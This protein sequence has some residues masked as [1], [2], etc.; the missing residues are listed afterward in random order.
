[1]LDYRI[2]VNKMRIASIIDVKDEAPK[3]KSFTFHDK[4]C[5]DATPGQFVMIWIPG[6][7]EV[8]MSLSALD[9]NEKRATI[10][11]E[12]VGQATSALHKMKAG[13]TLGV[14]GPFGNNYEISKAGRVMVVAGGTGVASLAPLTERLEKQKARI[15]LLMGAKT[16]INLVFLDRLNQLILKSGGRFLATTEDGSYGLQGLVT[17]LAEKTLKEGNDFDMIYACGPEHM[18]YKMFLLAEQFNVPFQASLERF[19]RCA[20]G[21][22]GTCV[23]GKYRVCRDGPIFSEQQLREV[24]EE[25]GHFCRGLDGRKIKV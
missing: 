16:R 24:K 21:L 23:I 9:L 19:M 5:A 22:C 11:A 12:R 3:V 15:T 25:F 13:D 20:I 4:L 18:M 17:E 10:T 1:L 6:V 7:D 14:R 2:A 8:P